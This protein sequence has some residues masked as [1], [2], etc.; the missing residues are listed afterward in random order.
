MSCDI[1]DIGRFSTTPALLKLDGYPDNSF[2]ED[3]T[4]INDQLP[5][6]TL[7]NIDIQ[8]I[9]ISVKPL[10]SQDIDNTNIGINR[11]DFTLNKKIKPFITVVGN[12]LHKTIELVG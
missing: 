5:L 12:H 7:P 3:G 11:L 9:P 8:N 4:R 10:W 1:T 2:T 6:E